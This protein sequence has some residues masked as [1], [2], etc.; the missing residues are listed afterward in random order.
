M[1]DSTTQKKSQAAAAA[2]LDSEVGKFEKE[3]LKK[4]RNK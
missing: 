3:L 2:N 4:V 1:S